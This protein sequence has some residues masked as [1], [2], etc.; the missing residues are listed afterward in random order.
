MKMKHFC[1]SVRWPCLSMTDFMKT[2]SMVPLDVKKINL[3][4]S[5]LLHPHL[6][7]P[8]WQDKVCNAFGTCNNVISVCSTDFEVFEALTIDSTSTGHD[9]RRKFYHGSYS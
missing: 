5:T 7:E 3:H 6:C 1:Q 9:S 2:T 4:I 8:C